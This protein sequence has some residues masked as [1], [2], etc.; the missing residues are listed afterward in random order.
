MSNRTYNRLLLLVAS[1]GGL[2]YG[3][4]VGIIGGALPYL[5]ATSGL[6]AG[7]LSIIVAAVLLGSVISTLFAGMVAELLGRKPL[8]MISGVIFVLS[9]PVIALLHGFVPLFLG[10]LL[11]GVSGG[12]VGIV[13][14][15]Y[16][17]ECLSAQDRGKGTGAFQWLLTLGI[18]LAL[19]VAKRASRY[20]LACAFATV[21]ALIGASWVTRS[22]SPAR[23]ARL[24]FSTD[25]FME[26]L[27]GTEARLLPFLDDG[28]LV[29]IISERDVVG[30]VVVPKKNPA[31]TRVA[32]VM[33][34]E[35]RTASSAA[36]TAKAMEIMDSGGFRHLP[37]LDASGRV[38]GVVSMRDILRERVDELDRTSESLVSYLAADGPGG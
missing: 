4:D 36:T 25:V 19:R 16:L 17:A 18:F 7:Q 31:T 8:M 27:A 28:R 1:F 30:R 24:L 37:L 11:Q 10:R 21:V 3:V 22:Y 23:A 15:L 34:R 38:V 14:P 20:Q 6:N 26:R 13:V 2:L 35:V 12:F 29:G 32:D 9:I 5:E 33:T